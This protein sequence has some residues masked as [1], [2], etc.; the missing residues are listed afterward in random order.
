MPRLEQQ[1]WKP[2]AGIAEAEDPED[3]TGELLSYQVQK[4]P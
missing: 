3:E 4:C 1:V 2:G